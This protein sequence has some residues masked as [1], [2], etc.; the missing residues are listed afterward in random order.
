MDFTALLGSAVT[1]AREY[2]KM[3][4]GTTTQTPPEEEEEAEEKERKDPTV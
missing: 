4:R 2:W 3:A 1:M